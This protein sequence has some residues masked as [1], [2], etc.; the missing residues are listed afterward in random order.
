M[1]DSWEKYLQT[2]YFYPTHP[3]SFKGLHKLYEVIKKEGKFSISFPKINKWLQDRDS[4]SLHKLVRRRFKRLCV[5]VTGMN[6]QYEADL[7]DMQK[8]K[9]KNDGVVFLL[10]IIDIFTHYLWVEP[11]K[12][13]TEEDVIKVFKKILKCTKKLKRLRTDRGG[14]FT[15]QKVQDYFDSINVEHW[16]SHNDEMKANYAKCIICTLK[17]SLLGYMSTSK[18]YRYVDALQKLVDSYNNT[19]HDS[20]GMKPSEVMEGEVEHRL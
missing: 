6:D 4:C 3:G 11:L 17:T 12:T 2:I 19:E 16:T 20:K 18:K 15:G 1:T 5:I 10:L 14:E 7:A 8:L 13:K 9:D